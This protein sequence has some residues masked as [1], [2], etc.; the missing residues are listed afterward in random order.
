MDGVDVNEEV[1]SEFRGLETRLI[2]G[3]KGT[4]VRAQLVVVYG[5]MPG[6]EYA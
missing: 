4:G 2:S 3:Y 1:N 5:Q 6:E